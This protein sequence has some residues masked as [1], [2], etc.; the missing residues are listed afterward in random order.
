MR[1][2]S[3][4]IESRF[5][6]RGFTGILLCAALTALAWLLAVPFKAQSLGLGL[7][8]L[9]MA[10]GVLWANSGLPAP[11]ASDPGL[12]WCK[13][14]ALRTGLALFGFQISLSEVLGLGVWGMASAVLMV[15]STLGT[16]Q[17]LGRWLGLS[18]RQRLLVGMGSAI[19]GAAAI[20]ATESGWKGR[21]DETAA[22]LATALVFGMV[23]MVALPWLAVHWQWSDVQ[24]GAWFGLS[25]HEMGHVV[26][27]AQFVGAHSAPVAVLDKMMRVFLLAPALV[28]VLR[29]APFEGQSATNTRV[30]V[31]L[32]GFV[33]A[34]LLNSMA[35]VPASVMVWLNP[36]AQCAL[37][38]GLAALGLSTRWSDLKSAGWKVWVLGA[39]LCAQ[40]WVI[41]GV[42]AHQ[43][44]AT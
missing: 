10:L 17:V 27:A 1:V 9:V 11:A 39:A 12:R 26:A 43:C 44:S 24:A 37:A 7:L 34:V 8:P 22:A 20:A 19:C 18:P 36:I 6:L 15:V 42:L 23:S 38:L 25:I 5:T 33:L 32:W 4:P 29:A 35:W 31:F 41:G 28:V 14:T 2:I 3:Q 30:P 13:T 16:A 40:L 21:S